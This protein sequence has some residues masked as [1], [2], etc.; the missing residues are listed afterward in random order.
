[1]AFADGVNELDAVGVDNPEHRWDG[2]EG[3]RPVLM[4]LEEAEEPGALGEPGQQ[5]P[6][7]ARQPAME[8]PVPH[9]FQ[10]MQQPQGDD[11]TGPEVGFG[12]CG[13]GAQLLID[14][15]EQCGDQLLGGHGLL[16]SSPGGM[17]S[18]SLE[19]AH[20]HD[21]KASKYYRVYWFVS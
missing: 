16:R 7:V 4:G 20:A 14:L 13:D 6:I 21:N 9:P 15:I 12:V 10:G 11:L 19:E 2:Q 17:L 1:A 5:R 18:T 8:G 3:P